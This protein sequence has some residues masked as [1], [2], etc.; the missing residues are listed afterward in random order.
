M[1][2]DG[3]LGN[4]ADILPGGINFSGPKELTQY[5]VMHF[6]IQKQKIH[7]KDAIVVSITLGRR[8]LGTFLTVYFPT[9]LL[10]VI[11]YST[12]LFKVFFFE[13]FEFFKVC[14]L[15]IIIFCRL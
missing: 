4:Y 15:I 5:Y 9:I 12:N 10:N 14:F 13:V 2:M 1:I 3:V 7:G 6:D 8:I 11:G